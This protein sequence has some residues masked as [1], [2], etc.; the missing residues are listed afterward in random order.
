M[1]HVEKLKV[2]IDKLS[3][4]TPDISVIG[5]F[6]FN[7]KDVTWEENDLQTFVKPWKEHGDTD[8]QER[9]Q[10]FDLIN[11]MESNN[12]TLQNFFVQTLNDFYY[13]DTIRSLD[14]IVQTQ[15]FEL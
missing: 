13:F 10:A 7:S 5:D 14:L 12:M 6:N 9:R 15:H 11:L 2:T 3:S 4:P 8:F 1:L